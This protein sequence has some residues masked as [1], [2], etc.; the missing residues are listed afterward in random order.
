MYIVSMDKLLCPF[1]VRRF[2]VTLFIIVIFSF[3]LEDLDVLRFTN[4][5]TRSLP[6]AS[7]KIGVSSFNQNNFDKIKLKLNYQ[8]CASEE[9]W[10]RDRCVSSL[11]CHF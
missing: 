8:L 5:D 11:P 10:I 4:H 6:V 9:L 3:F 1:D 7:C 2:E